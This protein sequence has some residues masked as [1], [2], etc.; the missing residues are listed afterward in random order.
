MT[1]PPEQAATQWVI[2]PPPAKVSA[3]D[4][5]TALG[6]VPG[7]RVGDS[8]QQTQWRCDHCDEMQRA[9]GVL[10]WV[11]DTVRVGD[12]AWAVTEA[13][14][15]G[16]FNCHA[17]GWCLRCARKLG[18]NKPRPTATLRRAA[19]RIKEFL[20]RAKVVA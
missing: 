16:Q 12:P 19:R 10:V 11:P 7:L 5:A 18:A 1:E 14:R 17:S 15:L 8:P 4:A 13:C 9:D 2:T 6:L 20:V 3:Q